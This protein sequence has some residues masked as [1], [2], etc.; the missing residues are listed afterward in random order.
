MQNTAAANPAGR[1]LPTLRLTRYNIGMSTTPR[2]IL[3]CVTGGIAA[4]K[5]CD[6]VSKLVQGGA[7][8][9]VAMTQEA[10]HFVG[11]TTFQALTNR[12]VQTTLWS[13]ADASGADTIPHINLAQSAD[14]VV[15]APATANIIA[16]LAAGIADELVSTLLL[17]AHPKRIVMAPAMNEAMWK[18]PATQRNCQTVLDW[19]V[20]FVG[21][22]SGWQACRTVGAGRMAESAEILAAVQ[23]RL[24]AAPTVHTI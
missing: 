20:T 16:K 10:T 24:T 21:P 15:V 22:G 9:N 13:P 12:P 18:H 5:V 11:P 2:T 4:Y 14:L 3:V 7:I 6:V 19:G 8:V 1:I 23:A 17:A